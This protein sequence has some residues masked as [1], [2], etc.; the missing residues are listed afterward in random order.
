M[1]KLS[2]VGRFIARGCGTFKTC[3]G[4]GIQKSADVLIPAQQ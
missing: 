2:V 1:G 3:G 4:P